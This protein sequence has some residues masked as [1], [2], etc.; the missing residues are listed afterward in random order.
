MP[1]RKGPL[2]LYYNFRL[3]RRGG[4]PERA[5][6]EKV[7]LS[8]HEDNHFMITSNNIV[9]VAELSTR[10]MNGLGTMSVKES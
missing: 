9:L 1:L 8:G 7:V 2:D 3:V 6:H 10:R 5:R 4:V